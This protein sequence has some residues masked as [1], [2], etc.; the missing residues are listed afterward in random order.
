VARACWA[1][2][3]TQVS[4]AKLSQAVAN[5][6]RILACSGVAPA[7]HRRRTQLTHRLRQIIADDLDEDE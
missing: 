1:A 2:K 5:V 3:P 4:T 7:A 6:C